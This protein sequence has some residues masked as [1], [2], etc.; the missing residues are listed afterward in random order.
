MDA[1]RLVLDTYD[2]FVK[3]CSAFCRKSYVR[4]RIRL[5]PQRGETTPE[6]PKLIDFTIINESGPDIEVQEAWFLTSFRRHIFS[7]A[8]DSRLPVTV[9][10]KDRV[11]F[12]VP[13][14]E[15]KA[16]LNERVKETITHGVVFTK[17]QRQY[18][19]RIAEALEKELAR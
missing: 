14:E 5:I 4:I 13:Y 3:A 2:V 16:A 10:S 1:T 9:R 8:I 6:T 12:F 19:S 18:Q 15:L 17:T 11:T 7:Q